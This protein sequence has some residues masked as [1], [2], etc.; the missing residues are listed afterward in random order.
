MLTAKGRPAVKARSADFAPPI[1]LSAT[2]P[3]PL[4]MRLAAAIREAIRDGRLPLGAALPPSRTLAAGLGVSRWTVTEAHGQ[5]GTE[6][7]VTRNANYLS[8]VLV[9]ELALASWGPRYG[10]RS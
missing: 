1:D 6:Q 4:H 8:R 9:P 3:G 10:H 5:L 2:R 7:E